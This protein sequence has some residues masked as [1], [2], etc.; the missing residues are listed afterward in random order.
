MK[1]KIETVKTYA[2][3]ANADYAVAK[4]GFDDLRYFVMKNEEGRYFPV[5]V[6]EAAVQRGVHFH[7]NIVG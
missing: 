7:F 4:R 1:F 3:E 6:G 2:T 5:F